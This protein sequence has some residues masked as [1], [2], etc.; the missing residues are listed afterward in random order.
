MN[1]EIAGIIKL[2][3]TAALV[4]LLMVEAHMVLGSPAEPEAD[5]A[6]EEADDADLFPLAYA[7]FRDID[8]YEPLSPY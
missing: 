8:F 3:V 5:S 7:P 4:A 6:S 1:S 2:V